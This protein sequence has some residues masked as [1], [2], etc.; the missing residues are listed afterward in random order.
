MPAWEGPSRG[1]DATRTETESLRFAVP[2][3]AAAFSNK[4]PS[5]RKGKSAITSNT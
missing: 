4:V 1:G 2:G 5:T 3:G